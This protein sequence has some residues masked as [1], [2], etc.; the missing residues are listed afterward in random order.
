MNPE[1]GRKKSDTRLVDEHYNK[2]DIQSK[3]IYK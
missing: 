1:K 2:K 3:E